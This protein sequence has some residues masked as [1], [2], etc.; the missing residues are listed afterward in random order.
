MEKK[1]K[2]QGESLVFILSLIGSIIFVNLISSRVH[3]RVDLTQGKLY[4]LS[5][6][7]KKVINQ[8]EDRL[9]VRL[10]FSENLP[11]PFNSQERV[12]KDLL[13]EYVSHSKGKI[14]L[15]VIHPDGKKE[16]EEQAEEDGIR[17]AAHR[18]ISKDEGQLKEGYRGVAFLYRGEV[19]SIPVL[20]IDIRGLEYEFTSAIREV[21][22]K[23]RT[24]GFITGHEEYSIEPQ[25]PN[26]FLQKQQKVDISYLRKI[27][28]HHR[29]EQIKLSDMK[30]EKFT[31]DNYKGVV[32]AG[33][34]KE[35]TEKE[36]YLL[37]QYLLRGGSIALFIDGTVIE[38]SFLGPTAKENPAITN[39]FKKWLLNYGIEVNKDLVMDLQVDRYPLGARLGPISTLVPRPYPP[40]VALTNK[41]LAEEHPVLFRIGSLTLLWPSTI[42]LKKDLPKELTGILLAKTTEKGWHLTSNFEINPQKDEEDWL[43]LRNEAPKKGQFPLAVLVTGK[44]TS[45]W[46]GREA[47]F[48]DSSS[49]EQ[50]HPTGIERLEVGE[51]T[52]KL[53]VVGDS[54]FMNPL[55]L[56]WL[57]RLHGGDGLPSNLMFLLNIM[58]WLVED[59]D[60]IKVRS[61]Q[62]EEPQLKAVEN[63]VKAIVKWGN[64][65]VW[66]FLFG[67]FGLLRWRYR[68]NLKKI[69]TP[70]GDTTIPMNSFLNI[71][72]M[73]SILLGISDIIAIYLI[74]QKKIDT[75]LSHPMIL[76]IGISTILWFIVSSGIARKRPWATLMGQTVS[77]V[78]I[79][80]WGMMLFFYFNYLILIKVI[81]YIVAFGI[82]WKILEAKEKIETTPKA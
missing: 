6:G 53:I 26:P 38:E 55:Y 17:K 30:P 24:I 11:P 14:K 77:L 82:M 31:P 70:Q 78:F 18:V 46:A 35:F 29:L 16:L 61:K 56:S 41:E 21:I 1:A 67:M 74:H 27:V 12:V 28:E 45:Y 65:I 57:G 59:E 2:Y 75:N 10:Y 58:D 20:P 43:S 32:I 49:N 47:P 81:L 76:I 79:V 69:V 7:T 39:E 5:E 60:L 52:G 9:T 48:E 13:E 73:T 63:K 68:L 8:L 25:E 3:G 33:P 15:E 62:I 54:D 50:S 42:R 4:T 71:G 23:K 51:K 66:P 44:F 64:V 36:L 22:G 37:D 34:K 40:W 72:L 80:L 19:K